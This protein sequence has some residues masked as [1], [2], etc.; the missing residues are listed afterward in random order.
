MDEGRKLL[1]SFGLNHYIHFSHMDV[2]HC[3]SDDE[4]VMF[5]LQGPLRELKFILCY[6]LLW[7][8]ISLNDVIKNTL[9]VSGDWLGYDG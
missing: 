9:Q 1:I 6:L 2:G 7:K 8:P 5:Q 4:G 3:G